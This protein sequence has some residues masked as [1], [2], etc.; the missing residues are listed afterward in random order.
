MKSN[1]KRDGESIA[2][3]TD[4]NVMSEDFTGLLVQMGSQIERNS[5]QIDSNSRILDA[6]K[7]QKMQ[8]D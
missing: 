1:K 6:Q 7:G 3:Q 5:E 4:G 2:I 8:D